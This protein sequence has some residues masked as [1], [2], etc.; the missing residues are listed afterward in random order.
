[1]WLGI[2]VNYVFLYTSYYTSYIIIY[3]Q[4][5]NYKKKSITSDLF[6]LFYPTMFHFS[7]SVI[8]VVYIKFTID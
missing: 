3:I 8:P 7:R 6:Q 4:N 1:M 2:S 5:L